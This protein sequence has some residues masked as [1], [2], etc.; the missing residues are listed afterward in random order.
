MREPG[1]ATRAPR[2]VTVERETVDLGTPFLRLERTDH[3]A[4]CTIDRP[5]SRNALSP[6]MYYGVKRA[7]EWVNARIPSR[8]SPAFQSDQSM[9]IRST[10]P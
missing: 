1:A 3:L 8:A 9:L 5:R 6:A 7:V 10:A 2:G 4:W